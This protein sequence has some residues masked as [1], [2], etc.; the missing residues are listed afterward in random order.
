MYCYGIFTLSVYL[1][2]TFTKKFITL[3]L[4]PFNEPALGNLDS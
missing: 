4:E 3:Y 1:K 2:N